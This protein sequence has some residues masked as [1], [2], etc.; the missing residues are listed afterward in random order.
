MKTRDFTGATIT[1]TGGTGSFGSTMIR[2]LLSSFPSIGELRVFSRDENKQDMMRR[3]INSEK[4]KFYIGDVRDER[5]VIEVT[6]G[7]N[8]VFHAAALKQV[9]SCEF[10]PDQAIETNVLGSRNVINACLKN[11]VESLVCLSTDKAVYPINAMGISKAMMEKLAL[12]P[13]RKD[14]STRTTISVTRYG[15]VMMSRGSVIPLFIDQILE[16]KEVNVTDSQMTRFLMSLQD[17]VDLVLHAFTSAQPGDLFVKKA[18]ASNLETLVNGLCLVLGVENVKTNTIGIRHGEK[19][20]ESLLSAEELARSSNTEEYFSVPI[21]NRS[22]NYRK[23]TEEGANPPNTSPDVY[24]SS[25]TNQLNANE[26]AALIES[27]PE[28]RIHMG[29]K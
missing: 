4:V 24:D 12:A 15:N 3:E 7:T 11:S 29:R 25:S 2:H 5:S 21:D 13:A 27:L 23:Y 14:A 17:S 22:L 6:N 9:P 1:I 18:P 28:F 16:R 19:L 20:H 26:V 8:F 10:F